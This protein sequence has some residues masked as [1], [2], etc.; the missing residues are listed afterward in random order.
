MGGLNVLL[1]L[2]E[3][4]LLELV[5]DGF[6][7]VSRMTLSGL[8]KLPCFALH[9]KYLCPP[10]EPSCFPEFKENKHLCSNL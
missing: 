2:A 7:A 3:L 9:L 4:E 6:T 1:R 10:T 8:T 5:G